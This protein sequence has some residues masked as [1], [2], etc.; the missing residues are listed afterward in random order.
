MCDSLV[1]SQLTGGLAACLQFHNFALLDLL[2]ADS[3][4][5]GTSLP[6]QNSDLDFLTGSAFDGCG[7]VY[8]FRRTLELWTYRFEAFFSLFPSLLHHPLMW[9]LVD[10]W[11]LTMFIKARNNI[12]SMYVDIFVTR[13]HQL[14][15]FWPHFTHVI[16]IT[17]VPLVDS[18]S[19][20]LPSANLM[21][22]SF[23]PRSTLLCWVNNLN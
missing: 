1:S 15:T 3:C 23:K 9:Y 16:L 14:T 13:F 10:L 17:P 4:L 11:G 18:D 12:N 5:S 2:D 7:Q 21:S 6:I 19:H 22:P 8:V 20:T